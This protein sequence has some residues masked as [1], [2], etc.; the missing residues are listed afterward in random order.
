MRISDWSSDVCSS[1]L[2]RTPDQDVPDPEAGRE[3][4][5]QRD[6]QPEHGAG[7]GDRGGDVA[8]ANQRDLVVHGEA[9][10]QHEIGRAS[11]R[12]RVSRKGRSRWSPYPLK[13]K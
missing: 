12:E 4:E 3:A 7:E 6:R 10:V 11:W 9:G 5:R 2:D 13:K 8:L 1:D